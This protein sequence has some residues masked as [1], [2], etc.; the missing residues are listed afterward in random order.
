MCLWYKRRP[1]SAQH[2][3][4]QSILSVCDEIKQRNVA[5]GVLLGLELVAVGLLLSN[6]T[7]KV[8]RAHAAYVYR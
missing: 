2:A 5:A 6:S 4:S 8:R 7:Y 1:C 3:N